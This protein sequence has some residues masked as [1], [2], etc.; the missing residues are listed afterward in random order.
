RQA[1]AE[2]LLA[3]AE[4][5][6]RTVG[7]FPTARP[8]SDG[9]EGPRLYPAVEA[10]QVIRDLRPRP[11][12]S[13]RLSV[14]ADLEDAAIAGSANVVW[15]SDGLAGAESETALFDFAAA[16]QKLGRLD[17]V[18][19]G[20]GE[21]ARLLLPPQSDGQALTLHLLRSAAGPA[22]NA[23]VTGHGDDGRVI[24][25]ATVN[26]PAGSKAAE[27]RLALPAELRNRIALLRVDSEQSA[28]TTVLL[29]ERWRRRPVGILTGSNQ[30]DIQPL[31]SEIYYLQRALG[32]F[33]EL[34]EGDMKNLFARDLAVAILP[35]NAAT[36]DAAE[37]A[38]L[39]A[40]IEK[41]GL[42]LRFAGPR[43]AESAQG[44]LPVA[45]R[46]GDR[47]LG[48]SMTWDRPARLAPFDPESPF[49]GLT[50]PDDVVIKRQ[51]LAEPSLDLTAKTWAKLT[52]GTPLVT[53]E[54]R[55][56]GW[57]VLFHTTA[58]S[59]W[60]NLPLS[61]L[62]VEMLQRIL[63]ASQG[64]AAGEESAQLAAISA[65]DG[66]GVLGPAPPLTQSLAAESLAAL[67]AVGPRHPPGYYGD[68]SFRRAL[69]LGTAVAPPAPMGPLPEGVT[70]SAYGASGEQDL[71]PLLLV[72]ALLLTLADFTISLVMRGHG[73]AR[74]R[75]PKAPAAA[76]LLLGLALGL[77]AAL[78]P[79]GPAAAQQS[80]PAAS[81]DDA[82]AL[83]ATSVTRLA[84]VETGDLEVD[85][86][87]YSGLAGLS[88]V[89]RLRTSVEAGSPMGVDPAT[90]ELAFFPL[91]YW[92]ITGSQAPMSPAARRNIEAYMANGGTI[93]FDLRDPTG[94]AQFLGQASRSTESLR[95]L[96]EGVDIPPLVPVPPD[97]V[98]T[99]AFYLLQDF[100]GRYA[101]GTLWV[102]EGL[103]ADKDGVASIV[104]GSNDWAGAW[105]INELGQPLN[106][107]VP[108][109]AHQ[110][111][112]AYRFGVN[113][114]MY[115]LTGNYK[116]DQVHVPFILE[117]LGQ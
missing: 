15:L 14:L 85:E 63:E 106:V 45:L 61:G 98:L 64:I 84:Y 33:T 65:L 96:L 46:G 55:G 79:G 110:R 40:W 41:G 109:G 10:R 104:I 3:Q 66:F 74:G 108:G 82:R 101:G 26:F 31:L 35:D 76:A 70:Q 89:L 73:S 25:S 21:R 44:P 6:G 38:A 47:I 39:D 105:A 5:D 117:R 88:R 24:A 111:E 94:G 32:P 59:D 30:Q 90:D 48:G 75:G 36:M 116:A 27:G 58:N 49:A 12:P 13:D 78:W 91:L 51:V 92:P 16:L 69:N 60:S 67:G 20:P 112:M 43:L 93:L 54:R 95:R 19:D 17:V 42:L 72:L 107:V 34:R 28:G 83:E 102:E 68:K 100:P 103:G 62:F 37:S 99:K 53:A 9:S 2:Q 81:S 52:D 97:H 18:A 29:D 113:L 71:K 22:E 50:V 80:L 77:G 4:R 57:L 114:V 1:A 86:V 115:A 56:N 87:S 23:T 11:W 8:A 7:V